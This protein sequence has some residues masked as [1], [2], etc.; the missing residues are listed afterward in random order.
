MSPTSYQA[1]PPRDQ[2]I[3]ESVFEAR[4]VSIG[5]WHP[6]RFRDVRPRT[7]GR[8]G[9]SPR[10]QD[11]RLKREALR[12]VVQPIYRQP[13]YLSILN[14]VRDL[15]HA[16]PQRNDREGALALSVVPP[17]LCVRPF[18]SLRPRRARP[19]TPEH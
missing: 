8:C 17:R 16:E 13:N 11:Y 19:S 18:R 5:G 1:A 9:I 10:L 14:L 4:Y 2:D 6:R 15:S 7:H 12:H 3:P